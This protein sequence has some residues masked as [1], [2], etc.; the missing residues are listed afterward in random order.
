M[1]KI[2]VVNNNIAMFIVCEAIGSEREEFADLKADENGLYDMVITLNGIELN[3]ERFLESLNRS[4]QEA[5]NQHAAD[6]LSLEYDKMLSSIHEIQEL[7]ENHNKI[8]EEKVNK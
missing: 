8:F 4:Y 3:V 6:I 1:A 5:V 7:L 2:D